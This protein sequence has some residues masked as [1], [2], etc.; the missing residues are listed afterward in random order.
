MADYSQTSNPNS[1]AGAGV[2]DVFQTTGEGFAGDKANDFSGATGGADTF[3]E[4]PNSKTIDQ[5]VEEREGGGD[6]KG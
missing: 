6:K 5:V 4:K 3:S 2:I 1:T